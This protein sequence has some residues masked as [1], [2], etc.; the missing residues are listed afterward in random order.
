MSKKNQTSNCKINNDKT[1]EINFS[2]KS[3]NMLILNCLE[4]K[5]VIKTLVLL[6]AVLLL[7]F[8]NM[9]IKIILFRSINIPLE[10]LGI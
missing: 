7:F 10:W 9:L 2:L 6:I 3:K 8:M 4:L 1:L 5:P